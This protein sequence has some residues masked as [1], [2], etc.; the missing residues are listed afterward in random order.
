[1]KEFFQNLIQK[2]V[3]PS[4][5][6]IGVYISSDSKMEMVFYNI[7]TQNIYNCEKIELP[8]NQVLREVSMEEFESAFLSLLNKIDAPSNC[9]ICI[10]LPNILTSIKS[11]PSDLEDFELEVALSS[12]SEK[13]YIFKKTEPKPSWNLINESL[14]NLT[15]TYLYSVIQKSQAEQIEQVCEKNNLKLFAIDVSFAA[16]LRGLESSGIINQNLEENLKWCIITISANNYVIAKFE[17]NK[18]LNVIETPLALRSIE[19]DVLYSTLNT[20]ISEKLGSEKISNL[21][22]V[23]QSQD[24]VAEK[25]ESH[26]KIMCNIHTI[27]KNKFKNNPLFIS[28]LPSVEP[29]SPESIGA[30]CWK[31]SKIDLNFNFS[32]EE[33]KDELHGLL[34]KIGV[35]KPIHL[36]LLGGAIL[37]F[38]LIFSISLFLLGINNYLNFQI[39]QYSNQIN[40]LKNLNVKP[41]KEFNEEEVIKSSYNK[42]IKLLTSYDAFGASIPEKVWIESFFIDSDL[43]TRIKGKAYNVESIITYLENLQK[44]SGIKG[45]K[46]KAIQIVSNKKS[47]GE[48]SVQRSNNYSGRADSNYRRLDFNPNEMRNNPEN[49]GISLPPPPVP[50]AKAVQTNIGKGRSY[51]EFVFENYKMKSDKNSFIN[52]LPDFAKNIIFGK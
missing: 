45:L 46:I 8:Y 17:G 50:E 51:Y 23:S 6:R 10:C 30:A 49:R 27:D 25:L 52:N 11:F 7:E 33:N 14:E 1:M 5:D 12:E 18:I 48:I 43:H 15:N 19:P 2:L 16:L 29:I 34:G 39:K 4:S 20:A 28:S 9:P 32:S 42:N 13:S 37:G 35:K 47:T 41:T 44:M 40:K 3:T 26:L 31:K 38:V 36:Y 21:Y 24:F 22:I